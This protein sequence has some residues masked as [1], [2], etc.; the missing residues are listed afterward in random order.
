MRRGKTVRPVVEKT[1][2]SLSANASEATLVTPKM[3]LAQPACQGI[4]I[5]IAMVLLRGNHRFSLSVAT[6]EYACG[7]NRKTN[8][9]VLPPRVCEVVVFGNGESG[10][11][12]AN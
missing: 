12:L 2:H 11:A 7:S 5:R 1:N 9:M 10:L 8:R 3:D 6:V 4:N